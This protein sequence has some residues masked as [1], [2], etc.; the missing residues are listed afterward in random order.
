M[1]N[2]RKGVSS[3]CC[4]HQIDNRNNG[5]F[6]EGHT[7]N[8][9][10]N[11]LIEGLVGPISMKFNFK[12]RISQPTMRKMAPISRKLPVLTPY[13]TRLNSIQR[14]SKNCLRGLAIT[15]RRPLGRFGTGQVKGA[16]ESLVSE[17]ADLFPKWTAEDRLSSLI[18]RRLYRLIK[19]AR[20]QK[21]P[22][23]GAIWSVNGRHNP[24][25]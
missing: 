9:A 17:C 6:L 10:W 2:I 19:E 3:S 16:Q 14:L 1:V 13:C 24:V 5:W 22:K 23:K 12:G 11:M 21:K 25:S 8:Q 4:L 18:E 20:A 15:P 7:V